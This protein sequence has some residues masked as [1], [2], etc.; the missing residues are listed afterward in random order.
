[1]LTP[2]VAPFSLSTSIAPQFGITPGSPSSNQAGLHQSE[3][4]FVAPNRGGAATG[5]APPGSTNFGV[6]E[7][8]TTGGAPGGGPSGGDPSGASGSSPSG[9]EGGPAPAPHKGGVI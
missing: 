8:N 6:G 2:P 3:L 9:G 5:I 4:G 7:G 1:M